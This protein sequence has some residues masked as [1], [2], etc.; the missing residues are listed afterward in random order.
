M[1]FVKIFYEGHAIAHLAVQI[2]LS[3]KFLY[4]GAIERPQPVQLN[5][6]TPNTLTACPMSPAA[7]GLPSDWDD[8]WSDV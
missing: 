6:P 3:V 1:G 5:S 8:P 2:N 4:P 7:G